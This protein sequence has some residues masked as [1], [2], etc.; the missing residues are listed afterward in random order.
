MRLVGPY[1]TQVV[2]MI[3]LPSPPTP[4]GWVIRDHPAC[5]P[6]T[7]VGILEFQKVRDFNID[8]KQGGSSYK[9]S[10][11]ICGDSHRSPRDLQFKKGKMSIGACSIIGTQFRGPYGVSKS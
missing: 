1:R 7:L 2:S 11:P 6:S 3:E 4:K 5:E 9:N 8:P 10:H